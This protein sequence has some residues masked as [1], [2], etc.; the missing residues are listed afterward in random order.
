LL[1]PPSLPLIKGEEQDSFPPL[2]R[3]RSRIVSFSLLGKALKLFPP[4]L[5]GRAR[6][7]FN[8]R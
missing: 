2:L 3:G 1:P 4:L 6:V 7:G 8:R 5:K